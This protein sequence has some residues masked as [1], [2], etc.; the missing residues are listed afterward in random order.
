MGRVV[1]LKAGWIG[2]DFGRSGRKA[3]MLVLSFDASRTLAGI[4]F[5][6]N[7]RCLVTPV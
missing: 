1:G 2:V 6:G 7:C 4:G 5:G 3:M